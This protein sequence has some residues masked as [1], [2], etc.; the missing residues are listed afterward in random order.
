MDTLTLQ[1]KRCQA[2]VGADPPNNTVRINFASSGAE[3]L[4]QGVR[5]TAIVV[6]QWAWARLV[7]MWCLAPPVHQSRST[8]K[9]VGTA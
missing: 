7:R 4:L 1:L 5:V 9:G 2:H 6:L 8:K 3:V